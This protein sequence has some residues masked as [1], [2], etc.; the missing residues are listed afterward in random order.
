VGFLFPPKGA[1][2]LIEALKGLPGD[3]VEVSLYGASSPF[4]Q[5]Y[6]DRVHAEAQGLPVHFHGPYV[7]DQLA[8]I[9]SCHDVLVMPMICE[10][11]FSIVTREALMAGLPVIAARRGALPEIVQDGVNGLL[12]EPEN[13]D[14]LRRC[15]AQLLAEPDLLECLRAVDSPVK[16]MKAYAEEMEGMYAEI[17]TPPR[18]LRSL[19]NN[20]LERYQAYAALSQ[21]H[22]QRHAEALELGAQKTVLQSERDR[23]SVDKLR[24]EQERDQALATVQ[25]LRDALDARETEIR[26]R[27]VLLTAI[28][29]STTWTL[30]RCYTACVHFLIRRPL[31]KLKQWLVG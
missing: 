19:Q 27:D 18:R 12:F 29:A 11:T 10:E 26:Q 14:D 13:A 20:L 3:T 21:A 31:G 6:A 17:C 2:V 8:A 22:E 7:H 4:W 30:Y 9:L 15:L 28:Y 24:A 16:T 1:H 25:E 5:P 23:L